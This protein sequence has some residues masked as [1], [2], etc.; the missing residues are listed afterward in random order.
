MGKLNRA[1]L[2]PSRRRKVTALVGVGYKLTRADAR[3]N[4]FFRQGDPEHMFEAGQDLLPDWRQRTEEEVLVQRVHDGKKPVSEIVMQPGDDFIDFFDSFDL[5]RFA[6]SVGAND[7]GVSVV[8]VT[9]QPQATLMDLLEQRDPA[10][11]RLVGNWTIRSDAQ[12]RSRRVWRYIVAGGFYMSFQSQARV[13]V[14]ESALL[15]GY[16]LDIAGQAAPFE[17]PVW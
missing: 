9:A 11:Q 15:L 8:T 4:F 13:N 14:L 3:N 2:E 7:W 10:E 17:W 5:T 1:Q 16:P 12:L 6:L